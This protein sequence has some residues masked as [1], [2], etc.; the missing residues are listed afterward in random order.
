MIH[1][2][3]T[4]TEKK[5]AAIW[6]EVLRVERIGIHD[7]FFE[8]GGHSLL[9]TQVISRVRN[10]F[11]V[12]VGLRSLFESPT[13][14]ELALVVKQSQDEQT[15]RLADVIDQIETVDQ[16]NLLTKIEELSD[17]DVALLLN[18]MLA[19]AEVIDE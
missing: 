3:Q 13:V 8:L 18:N 9:A 10:T 5:L 1:P 15:G 4:E 11:Q 19:E 14:F 12:E 16:D 7:N 17:E 2:P 6:E